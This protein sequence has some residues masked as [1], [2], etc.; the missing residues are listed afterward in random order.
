MKIIYKPIFLLVLAIFV[1]FQVMGQETVSGKVIDANSAEPLPGVNVLISGTTSGVITDLDGTYTLSVDNVENATLIFSYVGYL[2]ENV[3]VN[4]RNVIDIAM[5]PDVSQ[6]EEVVVVGYGSVKKSDLT[7]SISTVK[8]EDL[9]SMTVGNIGSSLQG[10]VPGLQ[11]VQGSGAP[12][13]APKVFIRGFTSINL[14]TDPL[15]VVDGVPMGSN[16]N[17]LN[18]EE[19]ESIEILKDASA[20]AIYGSRASNGVI[21]ITTKRG[22]QGKPKFTFDASFGNQV[23][24]KPYEMA[25]AT[26]Y[27]EIM[28]LSRKNA[29][30]PE[31]FP[32]PGSLGEGTDWWGAGINKNSPQMNYSLQVTGGSKSSTYSLSLNYYRQESFYNVGYWE[33][34][35]ARFTND[36]VINDKIKVGLS[37]NPRR[38]FWKDTPNWYQDYLKIDP[39]TPIYRPKEE[40]TDDLNEYSIYQRSYYTY[41]WNPVAR[42]SRQF[43]KSGYYGA[44]TNAYIEYEPIENLTFKTQG[45][46]DITFNHRDDFQPDFVIDAAHESREINTVWR[47]HDLNSYWTWQNTLTYDKNIKDHSLTAMVGATLEAWDYRT[48]NSSIEGLPNNSEILREIDAGTENPSTSGG[49]TSN[50]IES[51]L[52]RVNY[53]FKG[54]YYLT[55]SY[56]I[57]GSSKFLDNNKWAQ[58]PSASL[59]W[60]ISKEPFMT[61]VNFV[62]DLKIR[63]GWGRLGNQNLP[64]GV[65]ESKLETYY[66]TFG[67]GDGSLVN[68]S[69]PSSVKNPDIQWETVEDYNL[70]LDFFLFNSSISGSVEYYTKRT[71]NML[72]TKPY[73]YYSGYPGDATIWT[74]IGSME[75]KGW[76]MALSY[77]EESKKLNYKIGL[78]LTTVDVKTKKLADG[79]PV[80][81]GN[82]ERTKTV[83]GEEPGYFYGYVMD[84]IFQNRTEINSHSNENGGLFQDKA[85]PGDIRFKD[86]NEDGVLDAEDRT[87]IGSPWPDFTGGF[88]ASVSYANFDLL[89]NVYFS[90]GNEL[91]NWLK[92]DLYN[93]TSNNNVIHDLK[94]K[95]WHGEGTSNEIPIISYTDYNE[96]FSKFSSYYIEDGS[97]VRL[98][99]IQLGYTLPESLVKRIG[100]R[101]AR[102]YVSGQN[103]ITLTDYEGIDPEVSFYGDEK[104]NSPVLNFG[105]GGWTY[106]QLKTYL[107]GVNIGF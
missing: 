26:E 9:Q 58:F 39:V 98:K 104:E 19:I 34:Y 52:G 41:V 66:Y 94:S 23:F 88:N 62:D 64:G 31:L 44:T 7:S 56:R 2:S 85:Q 3:S 74:N 55:A 77:I 37:I 36:Y 45:A 4:G 14:S 80:I 95:A 10:K 76:E 86:V 40:R 51:F 59:A 75:A 70:G 96:N 57:D 53:N 100:L 38:E 69:Y 73:P 35:T 15:Y 92:S 42:E 79:A 13:A 1:S 78:T 46:Y 32:D 47:N 6:L 33:K 61:D 72:F 16:P 24:K 25:N 29:D 102:I 68:T 48:L 12:G 93:T 81:Y 30:L 82:D 106:P 71:S 107:I 20:S 8:G 60:R 84:G 22:R 11:V 90:V 21:L 50:S 28:N 99:N 87:K 65:Y 63:G 49:K 43:A 83:E 105:F 89:A 91:V 17:F 103:L 18:S 54:K 27:A 101:K 67:E 5:V 97:Y